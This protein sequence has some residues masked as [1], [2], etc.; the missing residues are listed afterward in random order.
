MIAVL[1]ALALD[2]FITRPGSD[3]AIFIY[4]A[5][6]ILEGDIPYLDRWDHKWPLLYVLNLFGLLIHDTWGL[7]LVQ[8]LFLLGSAGFAFLLLRRSFG[9][10]PCP[11]LSR[12]FPRLLQIV[13]AARQLHGAVRSPLSV[14]YSIR[15]RPQPGASHTPVFSWSIRMAAY[16]HRRPWRCFVSAQTRSPSPLWIAIGIYWL[17]IRGYSLGKIAWAVLGGVS[18][19]SRGSHLRGPLAP[20]VRSGMRASYSTLHIPTFRCRRDFM[21]SAISPPDCFQLPC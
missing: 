13:C 5:K 12:D 14:R 21:L 10:L 11:V 8:G 16:R 6:G 15:L 19:L 4:V 20:G 9:I 18:V 3:S 1:F 17:L 2:S 7:W